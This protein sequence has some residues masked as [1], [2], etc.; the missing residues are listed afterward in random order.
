MRYEKEKSKNIVDKCRCPSGRC[1]NNVA[2]RLFCNKQKMSEYV[3]CQVVNLDGR[4]KTTV[5]K[6]FGKYLGHPDLVEID[7]TLMTF[8]PSGHGKGAIIGKVSNDLGQSWQDM[9]NLPSLG[10]ILWK[11]PAYTIEEDRRQSGL[12]IDVGMS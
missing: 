11:L 6:R 5:D 1:C 9:T 12:G 10:Q 2:Q 3:E 8:Y 7:G 4:Y